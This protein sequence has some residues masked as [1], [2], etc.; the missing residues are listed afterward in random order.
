MKS[1]A[2]AKSGELKPTTK[3]EPQPREIPDEN[4]HGC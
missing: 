4:L 1:P 2:N 3:R